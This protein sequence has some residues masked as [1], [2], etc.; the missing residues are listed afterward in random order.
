MKTSFWVF[1]NPYD[2]LNTTGSLPPSAVTLVVK[3]TGRA[4]YWPRAT[5]GVDYGF[6]GMRDVK[7]VASISGTVMDSE[8]LTSELVLDSEAL[9]GNVAYYPTDHPE[10]AELYPIVAW[11]STGWGDEGWILNYKTSNAYSE[12]KCK[13]GTLMIKQPFILTP[14]NRWTARGTGYSIGTTEWGGQVAPGVYVEAPFTATNGSAATALGSGAISGVAE[15][16]YY[17]TFCN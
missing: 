6:L 14:F 12:I 11:D 13:N 3:M 1:G 2:N 16:P 7:I 8:I 10:Y 4:L 9:A 17:D 15:M 5:I